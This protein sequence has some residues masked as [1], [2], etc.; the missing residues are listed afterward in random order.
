MSEVYIKCQS[1]FL[2]LCVIKSKGGGGHS[3]VRDGNRQARRADGYTLRA[4]EDGVMRHAQ[5]R[6]DYF[7]LC[8]HVCRFARRDFKP[9]LKAHF[10]ESHAALVGARKRLK[11]RY[12]KELLS[13]KY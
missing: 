4:L 12:V 11:L 5:S 13:N 3:C 9:N 7:I 2:F 1:V 10:S 8:P 6:L